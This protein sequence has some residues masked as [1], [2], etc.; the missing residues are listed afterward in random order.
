MRKMQCN[1][2]CIYEDFVFVDTLKLENTKAS[3]SSMEGNCCRHSYNVLG[4]C[5][6]GHYSHLMTWKSRATPELVRMQT[7]E[8]L[9]CTCMHSLHCMQHSKHFHLSVYSTLY[10]RLMDGNDNAVRKLVPGLT[11]LVKDVN[12]LVHVSKGGYKP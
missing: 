7:T 12:M 1:A 2:Q 4:T 10:Q 8:T 3:L 5:T 9:F 6:F 11:G